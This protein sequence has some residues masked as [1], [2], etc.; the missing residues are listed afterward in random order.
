[1]VKALRLGKAAGNLYTLSMNR[2]VTEEVGRDEKVMSTRPSVASFA[3]SQANL[4]CSCSF[5]A[6]LH[7]LFLLF[8]AASATNN[9][10]SCHDHSLSI[11]DTVKHRPRKMVI[12]HRGASFHLPE[13]T[14]AAYRTALSLG[15]DWIEPDIVAS[16]DGVLFCMHTVDLNVTTNVVEVFGSTREPWFSPTDN[17]AGYWTFNFTADE[18]SQLTVK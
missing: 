14:L 3:L 10:Y 12:A 4:G 8:S 7:I 11:P 17:R 2:I 15:A 18:I 5:F 1:M 16:Q 9:L 6:V 13:H